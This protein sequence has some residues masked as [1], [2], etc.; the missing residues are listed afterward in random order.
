MAEKCRD[1]LNAQGWTAQVMIDAR[2]W[3]SMPEGALCASYSPKGRGML[4]NAVA[5]G[6]MQGMI[7]NSNEGDLIAKFDCDIWLSDEASAWLQSGDM[8]RCFKLVRPHRDPLA[9]GGCWAAKR[10]HCE[11]AMLFENQKCRCPES[12]LNLLAL[13][14]TG[15]F[16]MHDSFFATEYFIGDKKSDVS[17]T[18]IT[19]KFP[20][21]PIARALFDTT[22]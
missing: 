6:I 16:E 14:N 13:K 2:E 9:W 7:D 17:T 3:E 15:G 19:R 11:R 18:P 22:E 21:M 10:E 1:R 8:A 5:E 12:V 4:G 20:R